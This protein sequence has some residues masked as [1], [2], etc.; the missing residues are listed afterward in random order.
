[1]ILMTA[2]YT[3]QIFWKGDPGIENFVIRFNDEKTMLLW[4]NTVLQQKQLLLET[5]RRISQGTSSTEFVSMETQPR[6]ENPYRE[7]EDEDDDVYAKP[8]AALHS[9]RLA[10][11]ESRNAS[12]NSLRSAHG[13]RYAPVEP[14]LSLV[15]DVA[16]T[17]PAA[18]S[19]FSP[20]NDSPLSDRSSSQ[21]SM[22]GFPR[23]PLPPAGW[24]YDHS[25]HRTA[26][27]M[28]R[29]PSR[30]GT[31]IQAA[32]P[33]LPVMMSSQQVHSQFAQNRSRS[34]STPDIN[35]PGQRRPHSNSVAADG[36]PV[37]PVP[38]QI[39]RNPLSRSQTASPFDLQLPS[40]SA[41]HGRPVESDSIRSNTLDFHP[42]GTPPDF[43]RH[44]QTRHI[45]QQAMTSSF[46]D[47]YT[48][49]ASFASTNTD[50]SAICPAQLKVKVMFDPGP[51]HVT[52]VVPSSIKYKTLVDRIDSK[53][54]RV[55]P[56]SI[57]RGSARL[58]YRDQDDDFI[59]IKNDEDVAD[60]IEEWA[61]AHETNLQEGIVD[62][63]ELFWQD[64]SRDHG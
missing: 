28:A 44:E 10:P 43:S 13:P 15:T 20:S 17:D 35:G 59:V 64:R 1:M 5:V 46:S 21:A 29:V 12:N 56:A 40:R 50:R 41:K 26:P 24:S 33:S 7:I 54:V 2:S 51:S 39:M 58:R 49:T 38:S 60:A 18:N 53:M 16:A 11:S 30:D 34:A 31:G 25:K 42:R 27:A 8:A 9:A 3:L 62:D 19:Y 32:R 52:I 14:P 23:Q 6:P 37:P 57:A 47:T 63:F 48:P 4:E 45:A 55:A 61:T 36:V 22:Y